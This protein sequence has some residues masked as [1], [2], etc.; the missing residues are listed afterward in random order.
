MRDSFT[1]ED[2]RALVRAL[3]RTH[4]PVRFVDLRDGVPPSPFV[5]LRHDVDYSPRAALRMATLESEA[6]WRSTYF[7][8]PNGPYYNLLDPRHAGLARRLV[9]LGH[10]V[11]LHY[12]V[13]FL[14]TFPRRDWDE[15]LDAQ[16][17]LLETLSGQPV[18]S[19]AMHQPGLN[20]EDPF[21]LRMDRLNAYHPRFVRDTTYIS[22]SGRAWRDA[23]WRI[24]SEGPVP[25]R[26][27]LCLH[28]VNWAD[29]DRSRA[30]IFAA[31]HRDLV[32]SIDRGHAD[33][34]EKVAAHAGVGEHE[35]RSKR[36][37]SARDGAR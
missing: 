19:I 1:Y 4:L 21:A 16:A 9:D 17:R 23:A 27:Q 30:E 22:D 10:E 25:T 32:E 34:M 8:L 37:E 14:D 11:G 12:D 3:T 35:A 31:V 15:L 13:R 28:P 5:I 26:L 18:V 29:N 7:L 6:G 2:Y 20:G 36:L 33:L 24:L